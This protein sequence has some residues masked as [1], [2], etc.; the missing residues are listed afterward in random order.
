MGTRLQSVLRPLFTTPSMPKPFHFILLFFLL[1]RLCDPSYV[2]ADDNLDTI[3]INAFNQNDA[4]RLSAL[5]NQRVE[6]SVPGINNIVSKSQAQGILTIFFRKNNVVNFKILVQ[7]QKG[8]SSYTIGELQTRNG[9]YKASY[10][11][12]EILDGHGHFIYQL[13]IEQQQ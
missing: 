2:F 1:G 7:E 10:L 13:R 9:D 3:V 6:L 8:N 12:R 5:F 4:P 11:I